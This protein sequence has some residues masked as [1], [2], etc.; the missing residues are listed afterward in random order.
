MTINELQRA[1]DRIPN[2]GPVNKARR[3]AIIQQINELMAQQV[4]DE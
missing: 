2:V 4:V 3:R 1:L